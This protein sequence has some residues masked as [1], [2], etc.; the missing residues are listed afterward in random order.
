MKSK[1]IVALFG[2]GISCA[3]VLF[4]QCVFPS[5]AGNGSQVPN[6]T[7]VGKMYK[8]GGKEPAKGDTVVLR[9]CEYLA[10][11]HRLSRRGR[12]DTPFVV[13]TRTNDS[14]YYRFDSVPQGSYYIEGRDCCCRVLIEVDTSLFGDEIIGIPPATL[15]AAANVWGRLLTGYSSAGTYVRV[16]GLDVIAQ[17]GPDSI[18]KLN[19]L[20]SGELRL[21]ISVSTGT[22]N[23]YD[24]VA[25]VKVA[26]GT[27]TLLSISLLCTK[28]TG[29]TITFQKLL[30][31]EGYGNC[32]QQTG[33]G[34]YILTGELRAPDNIGFAAYLKKTDAAGTVT[35]NKTLWGIGYAWGRCVRQTSDGG[36][37]MLGTTCDT[38]GYGSTQGPGNNLYLVKADPEG[39]IV[40]TKAVTDSGILGGSAVRQTADGGYIIAGSLLSSQTQDIEMCLVKTDAAGSVTWVRTFGATGIDWGVGVQQTSDGGYIINGNDYHQIWLIKTDA[41]GTAEWIKMYESTLYS[42]VGN[43]VQQTSDGGFILIGNTGEGRSPLI[44]T[45]ES[46]EVEWSTSLDIEQALA[47]QQTIDGGYIVTGFTHFYYG[48]R[49]DVNLIK[50]DAAGETIWTKDFGGDGQAYGHYVEQTRDGGYIVTGFSN[51]KAASTYLIKTDENGDVK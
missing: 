3:W 20:P 38:A 6:S 11:Y 10:D 29:G 37:I 46:G 1:M 24:T 49:S 48:T 35:W 51:D 34:G 30:H 17:V 47:V 5:T 26:A 14:G 16:L 43:S 44:K 50:T 39:A 25:K 42:T 28:T 18:F 32:V 2:Y 45:D 12:L 36:Y 27:D 31:D 19:N 13:Q 8:A 22:A 33:D 21:L 41:I 4:S 40:W 15:A 23:P 9:P 7:I